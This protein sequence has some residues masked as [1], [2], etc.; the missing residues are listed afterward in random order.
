MVIFMCWLAK[1]AH[2]AGKI[3]FP[4]VFVKVFPEE[5]TTELANWVKKSALTNV[6][7]SSNH[8]GLK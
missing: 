7:G 5:I 1:H 4:N 2:I 8:W 6:D 3:L